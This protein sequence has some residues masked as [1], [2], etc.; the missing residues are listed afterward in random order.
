MVLKTDNNKA[1]YIT[2]SSYLLSARDVF[3]SGL[4]RSHPHLMTELLTL[5]KYENYTSFSFLFEK[6]KKTS[7]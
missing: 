3:S 1:A 6:G 7:D 4:A 5:N 2:V